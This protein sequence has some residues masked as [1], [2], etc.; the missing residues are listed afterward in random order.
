MR[1]FALVGMVVFA[2]SSGMVQADDS[3]INPNSGDD[4][5]H[6]P[7]P[8]CKP[9]TKEVCF[10]LVCYYNDHK[11]PEGYKNCR[12]AAT[13]T[14][15]VTLDGGEVE[16]DSNHKN[17]PQLEVSCGGSTLFFNNSARRFTNL[18]G[19]RI[20]GETGPF[21]AVLL[22]R[23]ALHSGADN[24]SGDHTSP[25]VLELDTGSYLTRSKGFCHIWTGRP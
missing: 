3:V 7:G 9:K 25:S 15:D 5:R 8:D 1:A 18:L 16:D 21:P 13:F 23:G 17:N 19:T 14:K 6:C 2:L 11:Q 12:A 10:N 4:H 22:P 20:Q 24:T